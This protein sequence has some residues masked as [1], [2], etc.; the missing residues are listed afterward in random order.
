MGQI[1]TTGQFWY[2]TINKDVLKILGISQDNVLQPEYPFKGQSLYESRE[3]VKC[4]C[5]V[6]GS[7]FGIL[8]MRSDRLD[9][10]RFQKL[11]MVAAYLLLFW[12]RIKRRL[13]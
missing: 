9:G 7:R 13:S 4:D 5:Y 10:D 2:D 12:Q 8:E 6:H 3:F 11:P 1:V